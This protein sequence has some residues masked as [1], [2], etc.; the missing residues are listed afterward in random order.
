MTESGHPNENLL[1]SIIELVNYNDQLGSKLLAAH[2]LIQ[3][4][5]FKYSSPESRKNL[6]AD[7][8]GHADKSDDMIRAITKGMRQIKRTRL[9]DDDV[10]AQLANFYA[11][12][13]ADGAS[14]DQLLVKGTINV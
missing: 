6:V 1:S 8:I 10:I 7:L 5:A 14:L 3:S 12:N 9:R 2:R 4:G 11:E 13:T